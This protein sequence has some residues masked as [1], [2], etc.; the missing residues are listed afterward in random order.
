[1]LNARPLWKHLCGR[2]RQFRHTQ[3]KSCCGALSAAK[4]GGARVALLHQQCRRILRPNYF[5]SS[6]APFS[7]SPVS[8]SRTKSCSFAASMLQTLLKFTETP[9][10][11]ECNRQTAGSR[12]SFIPARTPAAKAVAAVKNLTPAGILLCRTI[13]NGLFRRRIH[14]A[15]ANLNTIPH[16]C[17]Q[18]FRGFSGSHK[19]FLIDGRCGAVKTVSA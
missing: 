1:M 16:P 10:F 7:N 13:R 4:I 2:L 11:L 8:N 5:R 18:T 19:K 15:L 6:R 9:D 3:N 17:C 12:L 14:I